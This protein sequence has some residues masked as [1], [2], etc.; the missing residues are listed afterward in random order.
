M[1][2]LFLLFIMPLLFLGCAKE[3][4][5]TLTSEDSNSPDSSSGSMSFPEKLPRDMLKAQRF[6]LIWMVMESETRMSHKGQLTPVGFI[7]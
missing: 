6:L 3:E 7:L 1:K 4:E 5:S 2:Y